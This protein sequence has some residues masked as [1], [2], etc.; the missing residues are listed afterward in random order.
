MKYFAITRSD[1]GVSIMAAKDDKDIADEIAKWES[2]SANTDDPL[3]AVSHRQLAGKGDWPDDLDRD[4]RA[5]WTDNGSTVAVDLLKARGI[6]MARIRAARD[7]ALKV[8][9]IEFMRAV[10]GGDAAAQT[11]IAGEKQALRDL[12]ASTDLTAAKTPADLRAI[13]PVELGG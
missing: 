3:T 7:E 5:A 11:R 1:G 6:H 10:E 12:P 9:D 13:W 8:K 4:F 2:S